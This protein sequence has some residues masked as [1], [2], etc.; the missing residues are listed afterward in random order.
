MTKLRLDKYLWAI[1][2]YKTRT[3][4]AGACDTGKVKFNGV[5]AKAAKAV[6]VGDEVKTE[7]KRWKIKVSGLLHHRV[8]YEEAIKYGIE[9]Q[10]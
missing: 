4:A 7:E 6:S 8:R 5:A 1:R 9:Q 10:K 2:L 3:M